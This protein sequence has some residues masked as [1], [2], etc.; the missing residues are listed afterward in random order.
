[1]RIA[2]VTPV[3]PPYRGGIGQVAKEYTERLSAMGHEVEVLRPTWQFGNAGLLSP[4]Q[5]RRLA[6][7]DL[8]HLHYPF[9]GAAE[10]IALYPWRSGGYRRLVLT[11]HMDARADGLMGS[12]FNWHRRFIQPLVLRRAKKILVSSLDYASHCCLRPYLRYGARVVE[13][14]FGVDVSRFHPVATPAQTRLRTELNL[15]IDTPVL[16]FV[17][18]LDSAHAFKGLSVLLLAMSNID[19]PSTLV[20]VGDGNLRPSFEATAASFGITERVRFVGRVSDADLPAYFRLADV[21]LFPSTS[22]A[23]AFGLVALEASASGI[24]TIASDFP[25]VR[26][27]VQDEQTGLLVQPSD[28]AAL[29]RA[30]RRLLKNPDEREK[31]GSAARKRAVD[32]YAWDPLMERLVRL[33]EDCHRH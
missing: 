12:F 3:Y 32:E 25:G 29:A 31:L 4:A 8:V 24:P 22:S 2:Q 10:Q 23:E 6:E 20:V 21:H 18:G 28:A 30:I 33:Y 27:V 15:D 9:F 7:F 17:G 26:V 1:M 19:E 11:Y 5:L 16:L 14:P 13:L